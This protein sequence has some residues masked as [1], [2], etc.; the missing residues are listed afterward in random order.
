MP[1]LTLEK[2]GKR[3]GML[4]TI[5]R[6]AQNKIQDPAKLRRLI[7]DLIDK[8]QWSSLSADVK[9]DA[10]EGLLQKNAED[11]KGGAGQYFT[12]RPLIAAMVEVMAP[13]PGQTI[14]DPACGT[15]GFLLAAH[16]YIAKN[17]E[18]TR[19][20]KR[21]LKS[22]SF[23]GIELVD[24][25]TRLCAMNLMLHGIGSDTDSDNLPVVTKDA[26]A[27]KHGEYDIVLANPPFGK[28]SSV[29]VIGA[30]GEQSKESLTI[31]RDD[32]WA[33]TSN[34][35][36]N[37]LQPIPSI[38]KINGRAAVVLPD[39]VLFEGGAGETIRR[40]LLKRADVHT[41][42]RLPTGIFYAQGVKANVLFFDRKSAADKKAWTEKLWIYDLR[43]NKHF[44]LKEN[45][46]KRTDLDDIVKSYNPK[47]RHNRKETDRFKS[48]TYADLIKRDKANL[49]I[50]WLKDES[51]E[52]SANLPDPDV[53]AQEIVDDLE[54]ALEQFA[55]IAEDLKK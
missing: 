5:F 55:T 3:P 32:F 12:P 2:L 47:N 40:E 45:T 39:N 36:L 25:V 51:L 4:G 53:L 31:N 29:T 16:D 33:T 49:D 11:V 43:T 15:G 22:G 1:T 50:F 30:D 48:F 10:Y 8:E 23:F 19:D 44:T 37:F 6:K 46:L 54:A 13:Q 38:L 18:L 35:Q 20:Q 17:P 21:K 26:L 52:D 24:S 34:K 27:A 41:L 7:V 14:C 42:L 28:K 9:G